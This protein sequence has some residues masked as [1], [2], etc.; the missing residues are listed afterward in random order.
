MGVRGAIKQFFLGVQ[1]RKPF[2]GAGWL[3]L[4]S[5]WRVNQSA[6]GYGISI[7]LKNW[8]P[9][10]KFPAWSRSNVRAVHVALQQNHLWADFA[11]SRCLWNELEHINFAWLPCSY[12]GLRSDDSSIHIYDYI[13]VIQVIDISWSRSLKKKHTCYRIVL[14][15]WFK[16]YSNLPR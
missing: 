8:K 5:I 2:E 13:D 12:V 6:A 11:P 4:V 3:V 7:F 15:S 1:A 10:P 9:Q 14:N 16:N